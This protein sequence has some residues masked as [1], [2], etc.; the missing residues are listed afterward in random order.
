MLQDNLDD[1]YRFTVVAREKSF[2]R[3]A[4]Q[5]GLAQSTLSERIRALESRLNLRLLHRTTRSV[6]PTAAGDRLL[7]ALVPRL[8]DIDTELSA[9]GTSRERPSGTVRLNCGEHAAETVLWPRLA[10][11]IAAYPDLCIEVTIDE[12][13]RDIVGAGFDAGIRAGE[14]IDADMIATRIGADLRMAVVGTPAYFARRGR[15]ETPH[16]L[17]THDTVALRL[18]TDDALY[19]WE[20]DDAGREIRVRVP[21]RIIVNTPARALGAARAGAGL[22]YLPF[23]TVAS[24]VAEGTLE[25]VLEAWCP[26]FPGYHLYYPNR[27]QPSAAFKAVVDALR[28]RTD[29]AQAPT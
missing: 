29:V 8:S 21:G 15:P 20:F 26:R 28:Y 1:L 10:P 6:A 18:P 24:L 27:G 2:T 9:L 17:T 7:A 23:D 3:A 14:R 13:M 4:A 25:T 16:A 12:A 11:L 5:L 22:A 19:A